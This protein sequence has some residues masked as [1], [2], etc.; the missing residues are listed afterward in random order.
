MGFRWSRGW[1]SEAESLHITVAKAV[2]GELATADGLEELAVVG[3]EG[4]QGSYTA[5]MPVPGLAK[6][7]QHVLQGGVLV[8]G[9]QGVKIAFGGGAADLG[10]AVQVGNPP[11]LPLQPWPGGP[12]W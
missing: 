8:D 1:L 12:P 6:S 4:L 10:A 11:S 5:T 9:G 2:Q 3:R 7:V